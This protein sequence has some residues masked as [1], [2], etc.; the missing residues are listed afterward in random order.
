MPADEVRNNVFHAL[1]TAIGG[2]V[3]RGVSP[4]ARPVRRPV[5][6]RQNS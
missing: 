2:V 4:D 5:H 3:R 6:E 1:I